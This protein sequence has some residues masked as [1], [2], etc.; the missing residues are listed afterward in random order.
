MIPE[1]TSPPTPEFS[2]VPC[3]TPSCLWGLFSRIRLLSSHREQGLGL[4]RC[5]PKSSEHSLDFCRVDCG[6]GCVGL[7]QQLPPDPSALTGE[8]TEKR[9]CARTCAHTSMSAG[10]G[11]ACAW[12]E[13]AE[14]HLA[15]SPPLSGFGFILPAPAGL[16]RPNCTDGHLAGTLGHGPVLTHNLSFPHPSLL[17]WLC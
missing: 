14:R 12:R 13:S 7:Q 16:G 17:Q 1:R 3:M 8:V 9:V 4:S 11:A 6:L 5:F 2:A 10:Q 15:G